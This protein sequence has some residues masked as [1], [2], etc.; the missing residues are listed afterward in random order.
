MPHRL[1]NK[2]KPVVKRSI[3]WR[4][5]ACASPY[6]SRKDIP[7]ED[8]GCRSETPSGENMYCLTG[9]GLTQHSVEYS[10]IDAAQHVWVN[11]KW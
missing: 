1:L 5:K 3:L 6:G 7:G 2:N 4:K 8:G 11:N 9:Y 10:V